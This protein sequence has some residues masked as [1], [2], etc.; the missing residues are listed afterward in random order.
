VGQKIRRLPAEKR[1][2]IDLIEHSALTVGRTLAE[3]D[4]PRSSFC[5]WYQQYQLE[6]EKGLEPQASKRRHFWTARPRR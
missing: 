1:E 2:V 3:L 5:R 4:V 6:G